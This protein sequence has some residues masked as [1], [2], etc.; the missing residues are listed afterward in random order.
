MH[1]PHKDWQIF[2]TGALTFVSVTVIIV[3]LYTWWVL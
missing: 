2:I 1:S 3:A